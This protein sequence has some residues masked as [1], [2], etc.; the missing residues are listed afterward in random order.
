MAKAGDLKGAGYTGG[1]TTTMRIL[2]VALALPLLA[3]C[4]SKPL[5]GPP[6]DISGVSC[7]DWASAH[8]QMSPDAKPPERA[9]LTQDAAKAG[10]TVQ[11][12]RDLDYSGG[13]V[14]AGTIVIYVNSRCWEH[15]NWTV[16][17]AAR[18]AFI[19]IRE[20]MAIVSPL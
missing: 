1:M 2:I 16:G 10:L 4:A 6:P 3:A 20:W 5:S 11:E 18:G 19:T 12:K 13:A 17:D 9:W 14:S 15:P 8:V 7:A